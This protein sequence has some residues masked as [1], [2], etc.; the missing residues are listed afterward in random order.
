MILTE[1]G[2]L[3][4]MQRIKSFITSQLN[5]KANSV[6]THSISEIDNLSSLSMGGGVYSKSEVD[7]LLA[8]YIPKSG[9]RVFDGLEYSRNVDNSVLN[10][11]GGTRWDT[12][13][14]LQLFGKDIVAESPGAF[15]L[16]ATLPN[17]R[18]RF[19]GNP[20]GTLTWNGQGIQTTSDQR[21][22]Q[23]ISK[24]DN[25]L[26]DAWQDV[27]P[28]QFK[29]NDAVNEK[30]D[31]AR[32]HTGYVVQQIDTACKSHN[33]DISAYGLYCH[34]E[35]PERTEEVTITN[36]DGTTSKE[37]KVIEEA[38]EHYSLRYTEVYA[39]E[40]MYLRRCIARLTARIEELEK[41][42]KAK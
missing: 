36:E 2:V 13:A 18:S 33:L 8:D 4:L 21:L 32:L 25:A 1:N 39:V 10:F 11:N 35:Y 9:G 22:K 34:E 42:N 29:Y 41:G 15:I 24:I 40:C 12:G 28:C 38:S 19:Q 31:N 30:G 6:H 20:N 27:L 37:T 5:T 26:L 23:Q 7:T 3:K 17:A 16:Y 14:Q